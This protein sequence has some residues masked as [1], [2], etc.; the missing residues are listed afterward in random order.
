MKKAGLNGYVNG[1]YV[2][3]STI[4][5]SDIVDIH[6]N[7][8]K[9]H[10]VKYCLDL[11]KRLLLLL[12]FGASSASDSCIAD[13]ASV[14][15][16]SDCEFSEYVTCVSLNNHVSLDQGILMNFITIH[17]LIVLMSVVKM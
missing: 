16:I 6:R 17:M 8:M 2:D 13:V 12:S 3:Y 11:V 15:K 9:K 5:D 10:N 7:L 14:A 1:F 4:D